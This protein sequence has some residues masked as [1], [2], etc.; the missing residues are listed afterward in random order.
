[1]KIKGDK[2]KWKKA[3]LYFIWNIWNISWRSCIFLYIYVCVYVCLHCV[4][5]YVSSWD[6]MS[7]IISPWNIKKN[8]K[9]Y[10]TGRGG[11]QKI[12]AVFIFHC[13]PSNS[14]FIT[15]S[16]RISVGSLPNICYTF[17]TLVLP[18]GIPTSPKAIMSSWS[19]S[20]C[21]RINRD[22]RKTLGR[23]RW[24]PEDAEVYVGVSGRNAC[25]GGFN[26]GRGRGHGDSIVALQL[27]LV[28]V[29]RL[30]ASCAPLRREHLRFPFCPHLSILRVA[31]ETRD[32][33]KL[34]FFVLFRELRR[35]FSPIDH[36]RIVGLCRSD[37]HVQ[38]RLRTC[39]RM[40][41]LLII[42]S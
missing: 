23:E 18:H 13:L 26:R 15:H 11:R 28:R 27:G 8:L 21:I 19:P 42:L 9:S 22:L 37:N 39:S 17:C 34:L 10:S 7:D 33:K 1:M 40:R 24:C 35:N 31:H 29:S 3:V 20:R 2:E 38:R 5:I 32:E 30:A 6:H 16:G 4:Y 14:S 41:E 12:N 36:S 25:A